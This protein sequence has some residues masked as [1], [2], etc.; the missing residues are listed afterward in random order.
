MRIAIPLFENITVLD[1]IAQ[2]IQL[3]VE[4]DPQPPFD[5]GALEKAP[6]VAVARREQRAA[7]AASG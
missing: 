3:S 6:A 4:Y 2:A 5:G 1:A 7:A